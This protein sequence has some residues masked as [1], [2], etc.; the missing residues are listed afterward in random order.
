MIYHVLPG[1]SLAGEFRKTN[2]RGELIIC[3]EALIS[4]PIDA[5]SLDEF[6]QQRARFILA[7]YGGDEIEYHETTAAD[8][9]KLTELTAEDEADLWFEYELFCSVNMW[10]CV[11]LLE[12]IGARAYRVEPIGLEE[13]D[14]W[15]GFGKFE[16]DDLRSCFE[17]RTEFS[18]DDIALGAALWQAYRRKD[19]EKLTVLAATDSPCFPHLKEVVEAAVTQDMLPVETL[20]SITRSGETD[21]GKIFI[22]FKKRAGVYGFGDLQVKT[23]L[24]KVS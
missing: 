8:L 9:N 13:N 19:H 4:G 18:R 15:D 6:W 5:N 14:R 3:R 16:A 12:L 24:D 7:E 2:I 10:F 1:D 21:F 17:L 20:R 23:L 22:E 11:S